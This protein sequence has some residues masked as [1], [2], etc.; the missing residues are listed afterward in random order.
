M[1]AQEVKAMTI[2]QDV[3]GAV[4]D[5]PGEAAEYTADLQNSSIDRAAELGGR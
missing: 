2:Q 4:A 5:T 3:V 1:V